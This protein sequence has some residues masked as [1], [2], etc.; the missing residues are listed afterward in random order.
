MPNFDL[1]GN[2][3]SIDIYHGLSIEQSG[4]RTFQPSF[5]GFPSLL[6]LFGDS[7]KSQKDSPRCHTL[8]PSQEPIPIWRAPVGLLHVL[9]GIVIMRRGRGRIGWLR[10]MLCGLVGV[11]LVLNGYVECESEDDSEY[12]NI[13]P[14]NLIIVPQI[15]LTVNYHW[16]SFN[17]AGEN[18]AIV[19]EFRG[20]E[21]AEET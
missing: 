2:P 14:H 13:L 6:G 5:G 17:T 3:G 8:R 12:R 15:L 20:L 10:A 4:L 9:L 16:G 18:M 1:H 19:Q 11:A 21:T 7:H